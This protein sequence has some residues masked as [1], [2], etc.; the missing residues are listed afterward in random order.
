MIDTGDGQAS[1]SFMDAVLSLSTE[2]AFVVAAPTALGFG[3]ESLAD[4]QLDLA[5]D[6][7]AGGAKTQHSIL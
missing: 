5:I 7:A 2:S 4:V 3:N 6:G 1:A